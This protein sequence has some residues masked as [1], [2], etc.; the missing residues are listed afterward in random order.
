MKRLSLLVLSLL[1][2]SSAFAQ[3]KWD[4]YQWMNGSLVF[5][6][7]DKGDHIL[8]DGGS[9]HEGGYR[10]SLKK[11][12]VATDF[13]VAKGYEDDDE[14]SY[15]PIGKIGDKAVF[16]TD[17]KNSRRFLVFYHDGIALD[18]LFPFVDENLYDNICLDMNSQ[19]NG[20]YVDDEGESYVFDYSRCKLG[21]I[22][23]KETDYTFGEEYDTPINV[24]KVAG[25]NFYFELTTDGVNLYNAK[26]DEESDYYEKA[27]LF[28]KLKFI[29]K[30]DGRWPFTK[31]R[32]INSDILNDYSKKDLRLMRNEILARKGYAFTSKD[33]KEY[34]GSKSWYKPVEDNSKI[35]LTI[36]EQISVDI[37]RSE[38]KRR[39]TNQ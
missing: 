10:F 39:D 6:A 25:K 1:I 20:E 37:I 3:V 18:I 38:E 2:F 28:K 9:C 33:L 8:F 17:S 11:T 34:F 12:D 19:L 36:D 21:K 35:V 14:F 27:G 29:D 31:D 15:V 30:G 24:I 5:S 16:V 4:K 22:V 32:I 7:K 23:P 26:Y 13:I